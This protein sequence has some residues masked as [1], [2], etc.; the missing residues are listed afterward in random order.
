MRQAYE[1]FC[2]DPIMATLCCIMLV[3]GPLYILNRVIELRKQQ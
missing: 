1:F 3:L 2:C